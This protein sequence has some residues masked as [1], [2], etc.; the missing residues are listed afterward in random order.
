MLQVHFYNTT[1]TNQSKTAA[2][3]GPP[4]AFLSLQDEKQAPKPSGGHPK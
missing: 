4:L 3:K 1:Q 2:T